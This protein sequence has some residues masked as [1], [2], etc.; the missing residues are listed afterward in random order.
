MAEAETRAPL[1][2]RGM[3][4]SYAEALA[5]ASA[6]VRITVLPLAQQ[7][8][9]RVDTS[10]ASLSAI[11]DVLGVDLPGALSSA[12]AGERTVVW[13]GPD[14]WLVVDPAGEADLAARLAAAVGDDGA[15]VDQS[16]QRLSLLLEGDVVGLLAKGTALDLRPREF[17]EGTALQGMLAQAIVIL[18]SRSA[19]SSRVELIARSSFAAYVADWL[20]DALAD[21][22]ASPAPHGG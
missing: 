20:I 15:V 11:G 2:A 14:E 4:D 12:Q 3:L 8:N 21:P 22:L 7:L 13:L 1:A 6:E 17:P 9:L 18:V 16:G 10:R 19:D 5:S